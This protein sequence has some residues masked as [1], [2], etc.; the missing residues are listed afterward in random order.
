[1][2]IALDTARFAYR[3]A[4][5]DGTDEPGMA[6]C[7]PR[8]QFGGVTTVRE[9]V[10]ELLEDYAP[11]VQDFRR[12]CALDELARA[13]RDWPHRVPD[14]QAAH[15]SS[16]LGGAVAWTS[17]TPPEPTAGGGYPSKIRSKSCSSRA[18]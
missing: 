6:C 13:T 3:Q 2:Q 7:A 9:R 15:T 10:G 8:E 4:G 16:E 12:A 17:F 5:Y 1:M 11:H 18:A 14:E